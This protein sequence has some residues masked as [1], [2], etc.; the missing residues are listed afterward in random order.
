MCKK[1]TKR[2]DA[3]LHRDANYLSQKKPEKEE[4]K[5]GTHVAALSVSKQVVLM[6]CKVKATTADGSS[7]IWRAL[8]DPGSSASFVHKP[9]AEHPHLLCRNKNASVE[10]V[11]ATS[12]PTC[13]RCSVWFQ[14]SGVKDDAK[15]SG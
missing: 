13:T 14:V 7:T 1:Y 3:L 4:D 12:T 9:L 11:A 6:K 10:G 8:I 2:P 5:E 15:K